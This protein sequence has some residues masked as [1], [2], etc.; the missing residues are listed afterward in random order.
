M[1]ESFYKRIYR[2]KYYL[3]LL[4]GNGAWCAAL[5]WGIL[6]VITYIIYFVDPRLRLGAACAVSLI[7]S[8]GA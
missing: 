7:A 4:R 3:A 2:R 5:D 6:A 8:P 1:L